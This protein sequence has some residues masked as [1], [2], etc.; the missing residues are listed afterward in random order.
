VILGVVMAVSLA[1]PTSR[2]AAALESASGWSVGIAR[3]AVAIAVC[4]LVPTMRT[5][6]APAHSQRG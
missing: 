2:R 5:D 1:T 6:P 4:E 3:L